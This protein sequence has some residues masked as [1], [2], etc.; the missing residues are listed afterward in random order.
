[1]IAIEAA[2]A[3]TPVG[4]NFTDTMVA[5]Y[6]RVQL[7]EDLNVLDEDGEPLSGM[8]VRFVGNP[9]GWERIQALAEAVVDEATLALESPLPVPLILCCP[10]AAAFGD[11]SADVCGKLLED[12]IATSAVPLD[13]ARSR[14][15]LRGRAGVLE[16]LGAALTLLKDPSV[17]YCLVGGVD[18]FVDEARVQVLV[19]DRRVLTTSNRD[20][21]RCGEAGA[22]L[23]LSNRPGREALASWL[24]AAAGNEPACRGTDLPVTGSGMQEAMAKALGQAKVAYEGIACIA[25]DFSGEQSYFDEFLQAGSR[26]AKGANELTIEDPGMSVGEIG[27]AAGFLS[28]AMLAF[29]QA[30]GVHHTPSMAVLSCDGPERGAVVLGPMQKR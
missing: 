18:S 4:M 16:A 12:V 2:G 7:F 20:G 5:L 1:V 23:L 17:P 29:M 3:L 11:D 25:H 9:A 21:Y 10:E 27:A 13:R 22:M 28:V 6:T 14:L 24:G 15:L 30:K 26:L 19:D 8:K